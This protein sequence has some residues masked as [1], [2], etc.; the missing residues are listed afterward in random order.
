ML[1]FSLGVKRM[2]RT[3][4]E[5]IRGTARIGGLET[6]SESKLRWVGHERENT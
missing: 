2:D 6:K 5:V 3:R 1:R 4:N